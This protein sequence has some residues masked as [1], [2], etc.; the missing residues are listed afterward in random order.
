MGRRIPLLAMRQFV[1]QIWLGAIVFAMLIA[2]VQAVGI[3]SRKLL[4]ILSVIFATILVYFRWVV[5]WITVR[6]R[7]KA[8][9]S[10]KNF[11]PVLSSDP[12]CKAQSL[13]H[14]DQNC[15]LKLIFS[16]LEFSEAPVAPGWSNTQF[17]AH[18]EAH[19]E[20]QYR[21][22]CRRPGACP[23][24]KMVI[25]PQIQN[26]LDGIDI[27]GPQ[28]SLLTLCMTDMAFRHV[29]ARHADPDG[30][31][32]T[33]NVLH[34]MDLTEVR[35]STNDVGSQIVKY[36]PYRCIC[37]GMMAN[38]QDAV[39][40]QRCDSTSVVTDTG[41]DFDLVNV[42]DSADIHL[43]MANFQTLAVSTGCQDQIV[44][45]HRGL[46]KACVTVVDGLQ[47]RA[48]N[49]P[50]RKA[51]MATATYRNK[52]VPDPNDDMAT[53]T[54]KKNR[55]QRGKD[56]FKKFFEEKAVAGRGIAFA[57]SAINDSKAPQRRVRRSFW[58]MVR[59]VRGKKE[60][61]AGRGVAS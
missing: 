21:Q 49:L 17:T 55:V 24:A 39:Q 50:L 23:S 54:R 1:G 16:Y 27:D 46:W 56:V 5:V 6:S 4:S 60:L 51:R 11:Y 44:D 25:I 36:S 29:V 3:T 53:A 47:K 12:R 33:S 45:K 13:I 26:M 41:G 52:V 15:F 18:L 58:A 20:A 19:L 59:K 38:L 31:P 32:A 30:T 8:L 57:Y 9:L 40:L 10:N 43:Q 48:R 35:E 61:V 22:F 14:T 28:R 2:I 37:P 34:L 42:L 7:L